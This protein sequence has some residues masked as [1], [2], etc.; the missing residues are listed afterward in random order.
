MQLFVGCMELQRLHPSVKKA[1]CIHNHALQICL[2]V[3]F[4]LRRILVDPNN[5]SSYLQLR[6]GKIVE[7]KADGTL[8]NGH[9]INS[10]AAAKPAWS[11]G[12]KPRPCLFRGTT[13][14]TKGSCVAQHIQLAPSAAVHPVALITRLCS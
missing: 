2:H 11:T 3:F 13:A 8:Q 7:L 4:P 10:L 12:K 9:L 5:N 14:G 6:M 1:I